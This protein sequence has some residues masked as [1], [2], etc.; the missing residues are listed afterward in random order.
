MHLI[1]VSRDEEAGRILYRDMFCVDFAARNMLRLL[2]GKPPVYN[3][4]IVLVLEG[5]DDSTLIRCM[6]QLVNNY[7]S[8]EVLLKLPSALFYGG[9]LIKSAKRSLTDSMLSWEELPAAKAFPMVFYGVQ[10][11]GGTI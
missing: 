10:A 6:T 3:D 7:R 9:S 11:R 4:A 5:D 8:H 1:S 2:V